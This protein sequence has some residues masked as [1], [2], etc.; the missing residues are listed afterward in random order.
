MPQSDFWGAPAGR[1]AVP[2]ST[3]PVKYAARGISGW[4][5][6]AI[7]V[8]PVAACR[9]APP[10]PAGAVR[11]A[12]ERTVDLAALAAFRHPSFDHSVWLQTRSLH[13]FEFSRSADLAGWRLGDWEGAEQPLEQAPHSFA[14]DGGLVLVEPEARSWLIRELAPVEQP[15]RKILLET[16]GNRAGD[17]FTACWRWRGHDWQCLPITL[18]EDGSFTPEIE[19]KPVEDTVLESIKFQLTTARGRRVHI[20]AFEL[21]AAVPTEGALD[22]GPWRVTLGGETRDAFVARARDG[23]LGALA[24]RSPTLWLALG[25]SP[26]T[27]GGITF[28]VVA[29][30]RRGERLLTRYRID[31]SGQPGAVDR[32]HDLALRLEGDSGDEELFLTVRAD[33]PGEE[34]LGFVYW[35]VADFAPS[36]RD[37]RPDI[38]MVSLDTVRADRM[39]LYGYVRQTTPRLEA[40]AAR[41]AV[42]FDHAIAPA[43]WTLPSHASVFTGLDSHRHG[44]NVQGPLLPHLPLLAE[45]LRQAGYEARATTVG[46]VLAPEFGLDR[47]FARFRV[48]GTI[49]LDVAA[50]ELDAGVADVLGWLREGRDRP[51]F[52]FL[53]TYQAHDPHAPEQPGFAQLGG[54]I[55]DERSYVTAGTPGRDEL[56]RSTLDWLLVTP[57]DLA[58]RSLVPGADERLLGDLY[59]SGLVRLDEKIARLLEQL[60]AE[61]LA[62]NLVVVLFSD[63]GESLLE[64]GLA[65]HH[66]LYEENLHVPL[67]LAAPGI[68]RPG[69]RIA[70]PVSLVDI[71][72]TVLELAGL[73]APPGVDGISLNGSL[74]GREPPGRPVWSYAATSNRG[75]AV[76]RGLSEKLLFASSAWAAGHMRGQRLLLA[77]DP[78]EERPQPLAPEQLAKLE[79][80]VARRIAAQPS[81]FVVAL[82]NRSRQAFALVL[83][84]YGTHAGGVESLGAPAGCCAFGHEW[85]RARVPPGTRYELRLVDRHAPDP[86]IEIGSLHG[87]PV[88][89]RA[90]DVEANFIFDGN[91]W[92]RAAASGK[93]ALAGVRMLRE[94]AAGPE[95]SRRDTE[96]ARARL[97]ALGYLE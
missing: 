92:A 56:G 61:G 78:A 68:V 39:S 79:R 89:A 83:R 35:S 13:R 31:R 23:R 41:R 47:G 40:W 32:W 49:N 15:A 29:R 86:T 82:S 17:L 38:L 76:R 59:D 67:L 27:L 73:E 66:H 60:E 3:R 91:T 69:G 10:A 36:R 44:A 62:E 63:H 51:D 7:L 4:S 22:P 21:F 52:V 43:P 81:E 33:T 97:R 90:A 64:R 34:K 16:E 50:R 37:R 95:D 18:A 72:P 14:A 77:E 55:E 70:T 8:L 9:P 88:F 71:F 26:E 19:V 75:F 24:P 96:E 28:E 20:R 93:P 2:P 1:S 65:G 87:L 53:H 54:A 25:L 12:A 57:K 45:L 94:S 46:P 84:G 48:R 58:G 80:E 11:G 30:G 5:C 85:L 6:L 74:R 42:I